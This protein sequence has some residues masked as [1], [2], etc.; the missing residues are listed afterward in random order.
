MSGHSRWSQ[1][2]HKK[3]ITDQKRGQLFSKLLNAV[4]IAAKGEPN[5]EFN[6]R[7]RDAIEKA[8]ASK[9]PQEN[10]LRAIQRASENKNLE[11]LLIE[12]YGP[13]GAAILI[14][15]VSD[16]KNRTIAEVK[17]ILSEHN[18]KLAEPGS[19]SWAFEQT[20]INADQ[21]VGKRR[22]DISVN[23]RVNQRQSALKWQAKFKQE[24]S[25]EARVKLQALVEVLE[26]HDDVGGVYTN[27]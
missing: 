16:N 15:A 2:K 5:L 9:V 19:V 1:I 3:G 24:I 27:A 8:K 7:L 23:Q 12:A 22:L 6:P 10:I 20:Q 14:E 11:E 21:E 25:A 18:A 4:A 26:N 17:K 13:E